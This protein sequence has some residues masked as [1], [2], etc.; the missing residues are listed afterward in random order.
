VKE[1][2]RDDRGAVGELEAVLAL[3]VGTCEGSLFVAEELALDQAWRQSSTVDDDER[4]VRSWAPQLFS[5]AM[6]RSKSV[7]GYQ[8][9][10]KPVA[11][12]IKPVTLDDVREAP[13]EI[14]VTGITV[15]EV[16]GFASAR[17][18]SPRRNRGPC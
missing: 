17:L 12:I 10:M 6:R 9:S 5:A 18:R 2:L 11:A 13:S 4:A 14:G 1:C 3:A 7:N 15:I 8:Q 16:K